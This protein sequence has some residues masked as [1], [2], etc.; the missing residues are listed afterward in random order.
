K[1]EGVTLQMQ[2]RPPP[3]TT[4]RNSELNRKNSNDNMAYATGHKFMLTL[5]ES[6]FNQLQRSADLRGVTVQGL[7]R[8]VIVPEWN[9]EHKTATQGHMAQE[10]ALSQDQLARE[11]PSI[12]SWPRSRRT[13][14]E[15]S[16]TEIA[17]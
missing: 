11:S 13:I 17:T 8:P 12:N 5:R 3:T 6:V 16:P 4:K 2:T 14:E 7:I 1:P 15:D 9:I 10:N